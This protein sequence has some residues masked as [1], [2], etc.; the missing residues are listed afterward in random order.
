MIPTLHNICN[1]IKAVNNV[2][3]NNI[4]FLNAVEFYENWFLFF[5]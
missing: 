5:Q 3:T 1:E 4:I 2:E